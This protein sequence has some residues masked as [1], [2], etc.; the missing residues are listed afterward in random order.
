MRITAVLSLAA[1]LALPAAARERVNFNSGW[2]FERQAHGAGELGSF[3]RDTGVAGQV[4]ARFRQASEPA[5]DDSDWQRIRLPHTWNAQ[6][7]MDAAPGYWRGIG[8]YRKHF[9]LDPKYAGKRIF[10]EFEGVNHVA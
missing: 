9:R 5:Y 7:P 10:L 2:L 8:W 6:D 3:D 4:E 1:V